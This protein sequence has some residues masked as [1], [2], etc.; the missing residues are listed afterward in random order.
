MNASA[1]EHEKAH[2]WMFGQIHIKLLWDNKKNTE[3]THK[4]QTHT[5]GRVAIV[6]Q[7]NRVVVEH[8]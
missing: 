8:G 1:K 3:D 5:I 7:P 6:L 4:N 2:D